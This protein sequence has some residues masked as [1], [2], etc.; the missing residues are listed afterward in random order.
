MKDESEG[1]KLFYCVNCGHHFGYF[2]GDSRVILK[3]PRCKI[4]TEYFYRRGKL[5]TETRPEGAPGV[6]EPA[7]VT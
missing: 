5:L 6:K 1:M 2:R 4:N 3:C 7:P